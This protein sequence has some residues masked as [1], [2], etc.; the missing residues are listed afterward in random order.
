LTAS[1]I[2]K[3]ED[4]IGCDGLKERMHIDKPGTVVSTLRPQ[5][6]LSVKH[7]LGKGEIIS[8]CALGDGGTSRSENHGD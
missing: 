8:Q 2:L 5:R 6:V 1:G 3:I 4:E 7:E